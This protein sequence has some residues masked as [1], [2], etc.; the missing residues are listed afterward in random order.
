M[1]APSSAVPVPE[2]ARAI[3]RDKPLFVRRVRAAGATAS[4]RALRIFLLLLYSNVALWIPALEVV[5]PAQLAVLAAGLLL[6]VEGI[7]GRRRLGLIWPES[8]LI[9]AFLLAAFLSSFTAMWPRWALET[10]ID[11]T[12]CA[13]VYFLVAL[14]ADSVPRIKGLLWTLVIGGLFPACGTLLFYVR[15]FTEEGR[16][17]WLGIFANSN[18]VA[19]SLVILLPL[20][21]ALGSLS[22]WGGRLLAAAAMLAYSAAIYT[23]FSRGGLLGFFAVLVVIG[24]RVRSQ[25]MR[26]AALGLMALA[27]IAVAYFWQRADGFAALDRDATLNQRVITLKAGME[28]FADHPLLGV[29]AGCSVVAFAVY[30]PGGVLTHKALIVHNTVVQS[31][32]ELGLLGSVPYLLLIGSALVGA[33]Q[34]ARRRAHPGADPELPVLM[35]GVQA[36]LVGFVVCG[37]A[38]GLVLSWFPYILFGLVSAARGLSRAPVRAT[39]SEAA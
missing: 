33:H 24:L 8:P 37:L 39:V 17:G 23:T 1:A 25:V 11:L 4:Y 12:K 26:V 3:A 30:A 19:Y 36:S 16:S 20:A 6:A 38:S 29:G 31:L 22:G 34:L 21:Y 15:G 32:A 35:S 10:S 18:D 13:I 14:T 7:T 2:V 5:R 28:M 27:G 9:L